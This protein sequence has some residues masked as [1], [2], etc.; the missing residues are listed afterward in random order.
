MRVAIRIEQ[1]VTVTGK[2]VVLNIGEELENGTRKARKLS[3]AQSKDMWKS[4]M[5]AQTRSLR[6]E[7]REGAR[8]RRRGKERRKKEN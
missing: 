8:K 2:A 7:P 3:I 5:N 4:K 6:R 1:R